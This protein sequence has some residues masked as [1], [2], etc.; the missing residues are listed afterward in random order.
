MGL[1]SVGRA[2]KIP[3][4]KA[5]QVGGSWGLDWGTA[6]RGTAAAVHPDMG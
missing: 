2:Q 4:S 5:S 1:A 3:I 6:E